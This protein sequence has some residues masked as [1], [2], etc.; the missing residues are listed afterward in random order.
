MNATQ[1]TAAA[2]AGVSGAA[3]VVIS[4]VLS[5]WHIEVPGDVSAAAMVLL[6]PALHYLSVRFAPAVK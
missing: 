3:I 2:S 4:W 1:S 5:K 6:S